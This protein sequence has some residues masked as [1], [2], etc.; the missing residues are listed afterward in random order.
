MIAAI[1]VALAGCSAKKPDAVAPPAA[2]AAAT[3]TANPDVPQIPEAE[4]VV[5]DSANNFYRAKNYTAALAAYR[6]AAV[7]AP[8]D[9][10]PWY[11]VYM[12]ATITNAKALGD[13]AIAAMR[14]RGSA[15]GEATDPAVQA[16]HKAGGISP[17]A[18]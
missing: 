3:P 13:S 12:V 5:L 6:R 16:A 9:V 18:H 14:A 17:T 7:I 11:G 10:A 8:T 15:L 1:L 4:R 2:E